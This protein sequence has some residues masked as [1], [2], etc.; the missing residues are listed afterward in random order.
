[1]SFLNMPQYDIAHS[2]TNTMI[3]LRSDLHSQ[4]T[5]HT[6]PLRAMG[7][8]SWVIQ[9]T[10]TTIYRYRTVLR[11]S[12]LLF[13]AWLHHK[14]HNNV[15]SIQF[16]T[17]IVYCLTNT[18]I[19]LLHQC[20]VSHTAAAT[21]CLSLSLLL[22]RPVWTQLQYMLNWDVVVRDRLFVTRMFDQILF[23][24]NLQTNYFPGGPKFSPMVNILPAIRLFETY[25]FI[26]FQDY[27]FLFDVGY[28]M[29]LR[30]VDT[31]MDEC[32]G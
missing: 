1:M 22:L 14:H 8:L 26:Q 18:C 31:F 17:K 5:P 12:F 29:L 2:L 32:S 30:H 7:C 13:C 9:R 23:T 15:N 11:Y 20:E 27:A 28:G 3:K 24:T 25:N 6:S 21:N 10:M 16:N 4:T 19:L